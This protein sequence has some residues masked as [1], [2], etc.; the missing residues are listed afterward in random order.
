MKILVGY[1]GSKVAEDAV[2]L[3]QKHG[4]AF[5]A[6]IYILTSMEQSPALKK[7]DIDR[8]ESKLEK[9]QRAFKADIFPVRSK[10]P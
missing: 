10:H 1:D 8:A 5:K 4:H 6:E 9:L 7:E 2:K 3:A